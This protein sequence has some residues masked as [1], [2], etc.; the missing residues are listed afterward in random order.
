MFTQIC[1]GYNRR[2]SWTNDSHIPAGTYRQ[3]SKI[4]HTLV[5][6]K[7]DNHSI[8][9]F[10]LPLTPGLKRLG[11]DNC[12]TTQETLMFWD[13][14]RLLSKVSRFIYKDTISDRLI[15]N[16]LQYP[17]QGVRDIYINK[18]AEISFILMPGL[19]TGQKQYT[20]T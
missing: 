3:T 7:I 15:E 9:I 14:T 4:G 19:C 20:M 17:L 10:I 16:Q 1:I 8:Y 13:L 12:K 2:K 18:G 11:R 6:N 5:C